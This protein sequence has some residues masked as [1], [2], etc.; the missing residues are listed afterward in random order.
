MNNPLKSVLSLP[1]GMFLFLVL[2]AL[3]LPVIRAEAALTHHSMLLGWLGLSP[4]L[5][6]HGQVW[7]MFTYDFLAVG[8]AWW[9]ISLFWLTTLMMIL[10]RNWSSKAFWIYCLVAAFAGALPF[11]L[12]R[13]GLDARIFGDGAIVMALLVAW[14]RLYRRERL[15]M[16]GL[17][18]M[19]VRQAA[20]FIGVLNVVIVYFSCGGWLGSLSMICGGAAGWLYLAIGDKRVMRRGSTTTQSERIARL[21]I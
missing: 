8:V 15:V 18:E 2:Y 7:R 21:E 10:A 3:S 9:I 5:V 14:D 4:A 12:I 6:W 1:K 19:S 16:L 20:V 13:P 17:G 11:V